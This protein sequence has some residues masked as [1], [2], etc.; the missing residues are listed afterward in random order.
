MTVAGQTV[1]SAP[2]PSNRNRA[3][4]RLA[5]AGR[6]A[7]VAGVALVFAVAG[8]V[9]YA[10]FTEQHGVGGNTL[11]AARIFTGTRTTP[12]FDVIDASSGAEVNKSNPLAFAGDGLTTGTKA[13]SASFDTARYFDVDLNAPLPAGLATSSVTFDIA[14]ASGAAGQTTCLYFEVR[15]QSTGAVLGTFGSSGSPS[16]CVTGTTP[17]TVSTSITSAVSSTDLADDL[18]VRV[19][20]KNSGGGTAAIDRAVVS[21]SSPYASFTLY[22]VSTT[23]AADGT[24][25]ISRWALAGP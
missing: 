17:Q 2:L 9:A 23:D 5:R 16:G 13:W 20:M 4:P 18:R 10:L 11:G 22:P 19:Y 12:A 3:H 6:I 7:I 24:P 1:A 15:R 21:G 8:R 25:V 14:I